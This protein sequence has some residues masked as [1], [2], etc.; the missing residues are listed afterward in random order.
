MPSE[1]PSIEPKPTPHAS[2]VALRD[3]GE[4]VF[5]SAR[6][7][8]ETAFNQ[9]VARLR[10]L[11]DESNQAAERAAA[12]GE[13]GR[14]L[15]PVVTRLRQ[16]LEDAGRTLETI[17]ARTAEVRGLAAKVEERSEAAARFEAAADEAIERRLKGLE[18]GLH[19]PFETAEVRLKQ[20]QVRLDQLMKPRMEQARSLQL[21]VDEVVTGAE[22]RLETLREEQQRLLDEHQQRSTAIAAEALDRAGAI[23]ARV[24]Q[25]CE[26]AL[27]RIEAQARETSDRLARVDA[28]A[29]SRVESLHV[30]VEVAAAPAARALD[31][32][33]RAAT[34]V[35]ETLARAERLLEQAALA[36]VRV[37][38]LVSQC[39]RAEQS[40]SASVLGATASLDSI[41]RRQSA[42]DRAVDQALVAC[43]GAEERIAQRASES[44]RTVERVTEEA[45]R[46]HVEAKERRA[47]LEDAARRGGDLVRRV[48]RS[49][50]ELEPWREVLFT[51]EGD[52]EES[53]LPERIQ[54]IVRQA[55]EELSRPI[56]EL[57][58]ILNR[59]SRSSEDSRPREPGLA[60]GSRGKAGSARP[61][62]RTK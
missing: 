52:G 14:A 12:A 6:V 33:V 32:G 18:A 9:Y 47:E 62:S 50:A 7:V 27:A 40:L 15:S 36:S 31:E 30:A 2:T 4:E 10:A 49:L 54:A 45:R 53:E 44:S 25:A 8:D 13:A 3:V 17:E 5:L 60:K 35:A 56:L 57:G 11:I 46:L 61:R 48:E 1:A 51:G 59:V 29:E 43:A 23:E 19:G 24:E 28:A 21:L 42:A 39:E 22:R 38:S 55:Q 37:E 16:Q 26:A 20:I 41:E 34:G 58:A